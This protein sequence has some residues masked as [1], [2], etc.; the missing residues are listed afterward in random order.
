MISTLRRAWPALLA[1]M[2]VAPSAGAAERLSLPGLDGAMHTLANWQGRTVLLNFWATWCD[3]CIAEVA[4][5]VA[6]ENRYRPRGLSIVSVGIDEPAKLRNVVRTLAINY[7]VLVAE[8]ERSRA[9]LEAWG[10][11]KGVIP[12]LVLIDKQGRI[13]ATRRGPIGREEL[14]DLVAPLLSSGAATDQATLP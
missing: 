4:H 10:D 2:L 9:L 3:P 14:D 12:F 5:L 7:P 11:K 6:L 1:A 8:P 13:V